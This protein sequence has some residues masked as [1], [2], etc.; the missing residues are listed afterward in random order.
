[1]ARLFWN[2]SSPTCRENE[3][4]QSASALKGHKRVPP[5]QYIVLMITK[6][7]LWC[8]TELC[9]AIMCPVNKHWCDDP[10]VLQLIA[11]NVAEIILADIWSPALLDYTNT[12][13]KSLMYPV[14]GPLAQSEITSSSF[15]YLQVLSTGIS[16]SVSRN[17]SEDLISYV[18]NDF[19]S[20]VFRNIASWF[21]G[22]CI[23][24]KSPL[25]EVTMLLYVMK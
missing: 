17:L 8:C 18:S 15:L 13:S 14:A 4:W 1:M 24:E 12:D 23:F 22:F 10:F 5:F 20:L 6:V 9:I 21:I 2:Q 7:T 25:Q 3:A 16:F 11:K 19:G